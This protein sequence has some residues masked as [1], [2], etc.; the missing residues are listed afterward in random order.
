MP[1]MEAGSALTPNNVIVEAATPPLLAIQRPALPPLIVIDPPL[2]SSLDDGLAVPIP[3]LSE[4]V[5]RVVFPPEEFQA[6]AVAAEPIDVPSGKKS[7]T[8]RETEAPAT[9]SRFVVPVETHI[10]GPRVPAAAKVCRVVPGFVVPS[11][12][13]PEATSSPAFA[14]RIV[15]EP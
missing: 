12:V 2:T 5:E 14:P 8:L 10:W 1:A 9:S 13:L 3:T 15:I 7:G 6:P 4:I 11:P